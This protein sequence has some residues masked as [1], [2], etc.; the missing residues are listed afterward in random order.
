MILFSDSPEFFSSPSRPSPARSSPESAGRLSSDAEARLDSARAHPVH[1]PAESS[2]FIA[3]CKEQQSREE[4][5]G[6]ASRRSSSEGATVGEREK[7][8]KGEESS[9]SPRIP[10]GAQAGKGLAALAATSAVAVAAA[11]AAARARRP[12]AAACAESRGPEGQGVRVASD[13]SYGE[14]RARLGL[15]TPACRRAS[16]GPAHAG[17]E[18]PPRS[19]PA[20]HS[21]AAEREAAACRLHSRRH[22]L[23]HLTLSPARARSLAP[24]QGCSAPETSAKASASR[25]CWHRV[26]A[27]SPRPSRTACPPTLRRRFAT[28]S[29]SPTWRARC[30]GW[31]SSARRTTQ[32]TRCEQC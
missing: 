4:T 25:G 5:R 11:V 19:L 27:L 18:T 6:G 8:R 30:D 22:V 23:C 20:F 13:L 12:S 2:P 1:F 26:P 9:Y 14:V 3:H 31:L 21:F 24:A 17:S 15:A 10:M 7:E 32:S 29:I 16:H 28:R